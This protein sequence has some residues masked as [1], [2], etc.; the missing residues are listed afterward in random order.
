MKEL[1]LPESIRMITSCPYMQSK[2]LRALELPPPPTALLPGAI[3]Y[4]T[5]AQY[6]AL[7]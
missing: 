6:Q 4:E 7:H 5:N 2:N 3:A 1:E